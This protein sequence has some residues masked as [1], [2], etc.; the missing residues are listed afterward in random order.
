MAMSYSGLVEGMYFL[1]LFIMDT[2]FLVWNCLGCAHPMLY[3]YKG[4][5]EGIQLKHGCIITN[6]GL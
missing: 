4:V 2:K 6:S 3:I 5:Y 1:Y